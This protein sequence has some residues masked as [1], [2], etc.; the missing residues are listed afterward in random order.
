MRE[1]PVPVLGRCRGSGPLVIEADD[2]LLRAL[3][4]DPVAVTD[5]ES[6]THA[7]G[8]LLSTDAIERVTGPAAGIEMYERVLQIAGH[9]RRFHVVVAPD[10]SSPS[11]WSLCI[12]DPSADAGD[13]S[14]P[15]PVLEPS[16]HT[17]GPVIRDRH[18]VQAL[19]AA[20]FGVFIQDL[21]GTV[22]YVNESGAEMYAMSSEDAIGRHISEVVGDADLSTF[23]ELTQML[24][25]VGSWTG[26]VDNVDHNGR[27]FPVALHVALVR[28]DEGRAVS[29]LSIGTDITDVVS[30]E[31]RA[32]TSQKLDSLGHLT[33]GIAHD[34][35]NL[36]T[37]MLGGA[38]MLAAELRD[39]PR[40]G[41]LADT[42]VRAAVNGAD[43]TSRLLIFASRQS[44]QPETSNADAVVDDVLPLLRRAVGPDVQITFSPRADPWMV[45]I[46]RG[47]LEG[48]LVNI[49]AN[50]SDAMNATGTLEI[51]TENVTLQRSSGREGPAG[52]Y[53]RISISDTGSG[54]SPE[55]LDRA[56]EPFFT[57]KPVGSGTGLGLSMVHGF[58]QQSGG[59]VDVRSELGVGTT[60]QL[61]LPRAIGDRRAPTA[62]PHVTTPRRGSETVLVVD[63]DDLVRP[64]VCIAI[65]RLG[66]HVLEAAG[67]S[68]ALDILRGP[69]RVDLLFTD[70]SMPGGMSGV[71][72][73]AATR[74]VRP[75]LAVL[76]TSGRIESD[77]GVEPTAQM[78]RKPYRHEELAERLRSMLDTR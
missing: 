7:I 33:G 14:S 50:G 55:V 39:D 53:V 76:F 12:V 19:D 13:P 26:R 45:V 75:D 5:G 36:L 6:L 22:M 57:T 64:L 25:Q 68:D 24:D 4:A 48:A 74:E 1:K 72:L 67:G 59:F 66:Y 60:V 58:V 31:R 43:L 70:V 54:M 29:R 37:V 77:I 49:A 78:L 20:D 52:D 73:A 27:R 71:E 42:I 65:R 61:H 2:H 32:A 34:F 47:Q 30:M 41:P 63:D 62:A 18:L 9:P 21:G 3:G 44:L 15:E 51:V 28:D 8:P 35:N 56:F 11:A 69:D 17:E 16:G 23:E 10:R 38:E 46:D 40:L